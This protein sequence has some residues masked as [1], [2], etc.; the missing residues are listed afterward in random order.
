MAGLTL[1]HIYAP[2]GTWWAFKGSL[3][4]PELC[5]SCPAPRHHHADMRRYLLSVTSLRVVVFYAWEEGS[6]YIRPT[7]SYQQC[8]MNTGTTYSGYSST[9]HLIRNRKP[10]LGGIIIWE[11]VRS[12]LRSVQSLNNFLFFCRFQ[13]AF[14]TYLVCQWESELSM[15]TLNFKDT[16]QNF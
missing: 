11:W 10:G 3:R 14:K 12:T 9:G 15:K 6:Q 5:S 8:R 16:F 13:A 2:C 1:A 7:S 4:L